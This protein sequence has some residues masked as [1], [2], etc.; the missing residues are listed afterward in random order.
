MDVVL[1]LAALRDVHSRKYVLKY[2]G[3]VGLYFSGKRLQYI[4]PHL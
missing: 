3:D 2:A 1:A 4:C